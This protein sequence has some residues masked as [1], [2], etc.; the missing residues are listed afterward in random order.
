MIDE[1]LSVDGSVDFFDVA[2]EFFTSLFTLGRGDEMGRERIPFFCQEL[3]I[4]IDI[5]SEFGAAQLVGFSEDDAEGDVALSEPTHEFQVNLLGFM[6]AVDKEEEVGE[7]CA[8]EDVS[9]DDFFQACAF[10]LTSFGKAVAGQIHEIPFSTIDDEVVDEQG[11]ARLCRGLGQLTVICQHVDEAGFAHV[12]ASNESIFRTLMDR[13]LADELAALD[14]CGVLDGH[15]D[16][17]S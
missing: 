5:L 6:T 9:R 3:E 11:L 1:G 17:K 8:L 16:Q 15:H 4:G 7:L 13:A 10:G 12:G 14:V 2:E